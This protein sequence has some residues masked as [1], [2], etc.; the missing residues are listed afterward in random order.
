M[1]AQAAN[2]AR[3][4]CKH[5]SQCWPPSLLPGVTIDDISQ[6]ICTQF[7]R[8]MKTV[9]ICCGLDFPVH[10]G[11]SLRGKTLW[12]DTEHSARLAKARSTLGLIGG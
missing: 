12:Q 2:F 4:K 5:T 10:L 9:G 6:R 11:R 7:E 1:A 8:T 3:S